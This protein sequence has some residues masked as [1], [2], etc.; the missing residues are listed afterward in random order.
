[1]SVTGNISQ[2]SITGGITQSSAIGDVIQYSFYQSFFALPTTGVSLIVGQEVTIY[3]DSLIDISNDNSLSV[4]YTCGIGVQTGNNLVITPVVGDIGDHSLRIKFNVGSRIIEDKTITL[5]VIVGA[6]G[7]DKNIL[8]V[9]DST[10]VSGAVS[11]ATALDT[12]LNSCT[13]TYLGTKGGAVKYEGGVGGTWN[14]YITAGSVFFK[15]GV[16]DVPAYFTD[17]TIDTP[18]YVYIRLG[19]NDTFAHCAIAGNGLTAL[20]IAAIITKAKI[21]I[22]AFLAYNADLI[23]ILGVP[24]ITGSTT[25]AW[26]IDYDESVYSQDMYIENIHKYWDAFIAEFANGVYNAR[27]DCSYEA[28]NISR[29]T[30]YA[31]AANSGVHPIA[32]GYS[33]LGTGMALK[34]NQWI[35][36]IDAIITEINDYFLTEDDFNIIQQ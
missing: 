29:S 4:T 21:L 7:G 27:V 14:D 11:Y 3:G 16:V 6:S 36:S 34:I 23:V 28:I 12:I 15:A 25:V 19:I 24:T 13:L 20:E 8:M 10:M 35:S 9:G 33:Q 1:M 17:N 2:L 32:V 5:S 22:D 26:N 18:D 30:G 31:E